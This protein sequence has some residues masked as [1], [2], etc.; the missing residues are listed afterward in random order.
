MNERNEA[1]SAGDNTAV[2][3]VAVMLGDDLRDWRTWL[4]ANGPILTRLDVDRTWDEATDTKGN[5]VTQ[6]VIRAYALR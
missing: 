6:A 5:T 2:V 4:A 1:Y 3:D